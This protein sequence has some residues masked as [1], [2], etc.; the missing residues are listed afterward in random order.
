MGYVLTIANQTLTEA[1]RNR[2]FYSVFLF[3]LI[4]IL[5]AV[6]FTEVTSTT[7]DRVLKDVGLAAINVFALALTIFTGVGIINREIDRKSIYTVLAKPIS[8]FGY[9]L[10]KYLGLLT[11]ILATSTIMFVGLLLVM[12]GYKTEIRA[13]IFLGFFGILLEVVVL[14][15]I[16]VLCS[17]FTTSF[18]SA[19]ICAAVYISGHLSPEFL[20]AARKADSAVGRI[21]GETIYYLLPNL[22]RFNLK[23]QATYDLTI[24]GAAL[25][26]VVT[27]ALAY[28]SAALMG[29]VI[30]FGR[31]DFR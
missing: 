27:F 29:A 15:A 8:R 28:A 10:G 3:A 26:T 30:I 23:Y 2:V 1:R 5:N 7:M 12:K 4:V 19:F 20:R 22:E 24:S 25:A 31:R 16:A 11:I 18:V 14:G 13:G 9:I 21:A 17:S 6:V